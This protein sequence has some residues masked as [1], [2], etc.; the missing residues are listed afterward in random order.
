MILATLKRLK[1]VAAIEVLRDV[2]ADVSV[3]HKFATGVRVSKEGDVE[4]KVVENHQLLLIFLDL[5]QELFLADRVQR[6]TEFDLVLSEVD[7]V[8]NLEDGEQAEE[9]RD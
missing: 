2:L 9:K 6:L 4:D 3:D 1:G 5:H 7:L 8:P